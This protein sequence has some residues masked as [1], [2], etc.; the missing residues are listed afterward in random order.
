MSSPSLFTQERLQSERLTLLKYK[1]VEA[2][3][4]YINEQTKAKR[5]LTAVPGLDW[6][7]PSSGT[8]CRGDEALGP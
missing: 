6:L 3:A 1:V 5:E 8:Q 4:S 2:K 7:A